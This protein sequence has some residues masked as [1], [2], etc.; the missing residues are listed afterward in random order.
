MQYLR[1]LIGF[2]TPCRRT[3]QF[4]IVLPTRQDGV[5]NRDK[6]YWREITLKTTYSC[7]ITN[8]TFLKKLG[9]K[10]NALRDD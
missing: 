9:W 10:Q 4:L 8:K 5:E 7:F 2:S 6:A 1:D 3:L